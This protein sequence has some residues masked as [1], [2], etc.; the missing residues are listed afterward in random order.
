MRNFFRRVFHSA[1]CVVQ[2]FS[3]LCEQNFWSYARIHQ[4][5]CCT[6][7]KN[8]WIL[9]LGLDQTSDQSLISFLSCS[10]SLLPATN[11]SY[12]CNDNR[13]SNWPESIFSS[14]TLTAAV[15]QVSSADAKAKICSCLAIKKQSEGEQ[16][17]LLTLSHDL[18][19]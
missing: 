8:A 3:R 18:V 16:Q 11:T 10:Y 6:G 14:L 4:N 17:F 12:F 13:P 5:R 7:K 19:R 15:N 2:F 1:T 9:F